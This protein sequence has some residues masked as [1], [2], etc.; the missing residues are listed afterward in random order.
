MSVCQIYLMTVY[1]LTNAHAN[2]ELSRFHNFQSFQKKDVT[3]YL[4]QF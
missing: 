3:D 4:E 1:Y 2:Y